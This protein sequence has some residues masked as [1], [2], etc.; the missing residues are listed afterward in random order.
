MRLDA[1]LAQMPDGKQCQ[2]YLT[3]YCRCS[4]DTGRNPEHPSSEKKLHW[5]FDMMD[6]PDSGHHPA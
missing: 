1:I 6:V 5:S 2:V 3:R 4:K